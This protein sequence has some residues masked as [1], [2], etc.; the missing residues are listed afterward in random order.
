M[1]DPVA[2]ARATRPHLWADQGTPWGA[3]AWTQHLELTTAVLETAGE[4]AAVGVRVAA[5]TEAVQLLDAEG[6]HDAAEVLR[7]HAGL[8]EVTR[9]PPTFL[10][11]S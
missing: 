11:Q 4:Q 5:L 10:G 8:R 9:R 6:H 2:V 7:E 3:E 1:T